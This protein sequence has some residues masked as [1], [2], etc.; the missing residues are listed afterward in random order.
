MKFCWNIKKQTGRVV[1]E[2]FWD[3]A[4]FSLIEVDQNFMNEGD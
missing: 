2:A 1:M 3:I 4:L